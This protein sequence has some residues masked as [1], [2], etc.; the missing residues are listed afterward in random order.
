MLLR[1]DRM[2]GLAVITSQGKLP[3]VVNFS[4]TWARLCGVPVAA[5]S[6]RGANIARAAA[7]TATPTCSHTHWLGTTRCY[8]TV[9][10]RART[11]CAFHIHAQLSLED[12]FNI[13]RELSGA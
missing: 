8:H 6:L 9:L 7:D 5:V 1:D 4:P 3:V 10:M 2:T 12:L 11:C 13:S